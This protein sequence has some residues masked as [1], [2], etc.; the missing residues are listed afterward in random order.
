MIECLC[1]KPPDKASLQG[2][3]SLGKRVLA[4]VA[5]SPKTRCLVF[6]DM[7]CLFVCDQTQSKAMDFQ[8]EPFQNTVDPEVRAYV[9][10]LVSAVS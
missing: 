3:S 9:Y 4:S 2:S 6:L 7:H 8:E 1:C 5:S 10:S